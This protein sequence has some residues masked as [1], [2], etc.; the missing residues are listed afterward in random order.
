MD[1]HQ[2]A[3]EALV[4]R[5]AQVIVKVFALVH[6][7]RGALGA[8]DALCVQVVVVLISPMDVHQGALEALAVQDTQV[9]VKVAALVV[10]RGALD[11]LGVQVVAEVRALVDLR[12]V[13]KWFPVDAKRGAGVLDAQALAEMAVLMDAVV[14]V[15]R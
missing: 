10:Q 6:V 7:Q 3:L 5:D 12:R 11:T 1:V 4:V 15:G 8:L 9:I 2:Y 13:A 14:L